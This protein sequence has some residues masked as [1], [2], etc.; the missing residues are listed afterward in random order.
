MDA[1][2]ELPLEEKL[3]AEEKLDVEMYDAQSLDGPGTAWTPNEDEEG[4]EILNAPLPAI[5]RADAW[6]CTFAGLALLE[7]DEDEIE[8]VDEGKIESRRYS[9]APNKTAAAKCL[10]KNSIQKQRRLSSGSG[11]ML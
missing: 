3:D 8:D 7:P 6:E 9:A 5:I 1:F 11:Q 10:G 4:L 2:E